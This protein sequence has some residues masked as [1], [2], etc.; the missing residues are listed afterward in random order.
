[1]IVKIKTPKKARS[2]HDSVDQKRKSGREAHAILDNISNLTGQKKKEVQ[3]I[4]P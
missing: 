2:R 1:M 3:E 4:M